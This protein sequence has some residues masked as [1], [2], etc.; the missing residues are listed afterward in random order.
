MV[1]Y[2]SE[3]VVAIISFFAGVGCTILIQNVKTKDSNGHRDLTQKIEG[4]SN[5]QSG[6]DTYGR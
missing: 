4:N 5:T 3:I 2:I 6:R 1:E